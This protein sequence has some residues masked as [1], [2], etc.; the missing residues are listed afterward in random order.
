MYIFYALKW[1]IGNKKVTIYF[2][3]LFL[4]FLQ[5]SV[6]IYFISD[7][8]KCMSKYP[9]AI[10]F[11]YSIFLAKIRKSVPTVV[12]CMVGGNS[13]FFKHYVHSFL[14]HTGGFRNHPAILSHAW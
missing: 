3:Y 10:I 4:Q 7:I 13:Y 2:L 14:E 11:S 12:G 8:W 9:P 1:F 5:I 6:P